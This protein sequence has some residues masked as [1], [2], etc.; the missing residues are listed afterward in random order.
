VK[1]ALAFASSLFSRISLVIVVFGILVS[2]WLFGCVELW[3]SYLVFIAVLIGCGLMLISL[4]INPPSSWPCRNILYLMLGYLMFLWFQQSEISSRHSMVDSKDVTLFEQV[5][6]KEKYSEIIS[7]RSIHPRQ[8]VSYSPEATRES[9]FVSFVCFAVMFVVLQSTASVKTISNI[10]LVVFLSTLA[11]GLVGLQYKVSDNRDLLGVYSAR[12]SGDVFASFTNK[13][14]F[15]ALANMAIG[16]GG[17]YLGP[18]VMKA[19]SVFRQQLP[20]AG[21]KLSF[22]N[23]ML[24]WA[25]P[26]VMLLMGVML[27]F[28]TFLTLSRG[29]VLSLIAG[30]VFVCILAGIREKLKRSAWL[31]V[32]GLCLLLGC[33]ALYSTKIMVHG[34][35]NDLVA[36]LQNPLQDTRA[37]VAG[38]VSSIIRDHLI[39]GTGLGTFQYIYPAYQAD[40]IKPGRFLHAHND[41]LQYFSETG[42]VGALL[43]ILFLI[44]VFH[45][46]I[47]ILTYADRVTRLMTYGF[48]FSLVSIMVHSLFDYSLHKTPILLTASFAVGS[49]LRLYKQTSP[50]RVI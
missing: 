1:P 33:A 30:L 14:H 17:V 29:A 43:L 3:M 50:R 27:M 19:Y 25:Q 22:F 35:V 12:Y 34:R 42:V 39:F 6:E 23:D 44:T 20:H 18:M 4:C 26:S 28:I 8:A 32:L 36:S 10:C 49:L 5:L 24:I 37:I 48:L 13:N 31:V 15:A 46:S 38:D 47:R 9:M 40:A 11:L 7:G 41:W 16:F 2:S 45:A 21:S